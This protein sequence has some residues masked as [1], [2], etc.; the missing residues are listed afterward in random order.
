VSL[1]LFP[2]LYTILSSL[3]IYSYPPPVA[4][5]RPWWWDQALDGDAPSSASAQATQE[6]NEKLQRELSHLD[7]EF[8]E[9]VCAMSLE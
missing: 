9:Q 3:L 4:A 1:S 5:E 6:E 7:V 2:A 8:F